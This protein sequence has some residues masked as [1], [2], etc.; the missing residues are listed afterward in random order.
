MILL[1]TSFVIAALFW[2]PYFAVLIAAAMVFNANY[3]IAVA[4]SQ[5]MSVMAL[6]LWAVNGGF[7]ES[8]MVVIRLLSMLTVFVAWGATFLYVTP[9]YVGPLLILGSFFAEGVG[10]LLHVVPH[11]LVPRL[12]IGITGLVL[13]LAWILMH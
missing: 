5:M 7:G 4:N 2:Q 13:G 8:A 3:R 1:M 6:P 9:W 10:I 12:F 11:D